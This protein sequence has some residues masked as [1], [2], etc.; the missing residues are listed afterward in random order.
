[1][2]KKIIKEG[3]K[4]SYQFDCKF[5]KCEWL[6]DEWKMEDTNAMHGYGLFMTGTRQTIPSSICPTCGWKSQ[7]WKVENNEKET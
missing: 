7:S 6:D 5:C 3:F 4:E 2:T 1:M